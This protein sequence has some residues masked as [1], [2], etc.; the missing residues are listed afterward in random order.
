M[1]L[2]IQ[3]VT[4]KTGPFKGQIKHIISTVND[5][6]NPAIHTVNSYPAAFDWIKN[7]EANA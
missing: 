1:K 6:K 2:F 4:P 3:Q 7:K 5:P